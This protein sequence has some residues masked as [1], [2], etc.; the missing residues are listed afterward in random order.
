MVIGLAIQVL[1]EKVRDHFVNLLVT[2]D[3]QEWWIVARYVGC[4]AGSSAVAFI[5]I[6]NLLA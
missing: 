3:D 1:V 5:L 2:L 4:R 6:E